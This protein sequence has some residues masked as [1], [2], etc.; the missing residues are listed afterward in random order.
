MVVLVISIVSG[1]AALCHP[2]PPPLP[3]D[4]SLV[5]KPSPICQCDV[6]LYL[7]PV[8]CRRHYVFGLSVRPYGNLVNTKSQE[9][10]GGYLAHLSRR[11]K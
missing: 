11:L 5:D 8:G 10:L 3:I 4:N 7:R 6:F 1:N 2:P 9:P